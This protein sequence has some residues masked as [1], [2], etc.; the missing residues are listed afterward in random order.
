MIWELKIFKVGH[1]GIINTAK[2]KA[3]VSHSIGV[4]VS[5]NSFIC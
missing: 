5:K 2:I 4:V 1:I 3:L